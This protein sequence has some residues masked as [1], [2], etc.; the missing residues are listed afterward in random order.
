MRRGAGRRR[1]GPESPFPSA[2]GGADKR[3][4]AAARVD[5]CHGRVRPRALRLRTRLEKGRLRAAERSD[6]RGLPSLRPGQPGPCCDPVRGDVSLPAKPSI[7]CSFGLR[8][9]DWVRDVAAPLT[10]A[11]TG[12]KLV[13][14]ETGQDF[15]CTARYDKPGALPSEHAKGDA[16]D[17]VSFV[18]ADKRR[19]TVKALGPLVR[20]ANDS[21]RLFHD[22][23]GPGR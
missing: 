2:I 13:E 18:L 1:A 12:Q 20:S 11:Y 17:L 19:M 21:L 9:T 14:I 15:A 22:G 8:F 10:F 5:E 6:A 7:L 23:P 4:R 3:R 16:I